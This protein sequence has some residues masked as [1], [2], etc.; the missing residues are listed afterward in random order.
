MMEHILIYLDNCAFNR[1]Y[2]DQ[3]FMRIKL[4]TDAKLYI[5]DEIKAH[6]LALAWSYMLDFENAM[7]PFQE[8]RAQIQQ[9]KIYAETTIE[10]QENILIAANALLRLGLKK[11][12]AIHLACANALTCHY[13]ITTDDGV[14][15][16]RKDVDGITIVNPVEF[17]IIWEGRA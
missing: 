14:L 10:E 1:P 4:E 3:S 17:V 7:N 2:D 15:K 12:D 6:H 11:K 5:Q 13:F 8:H 16:K 9:W